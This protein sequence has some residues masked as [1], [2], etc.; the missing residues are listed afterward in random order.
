MLAFHFADDQNVL[1]IK[2]QYMFGDSI[3][4]CP[5]TEPMYFEKDSLRIEAKH[6]RAVYFPKGCEWYDYYSGTKY[7]GGTTAEVAA[8]IDIIPL[9]VK[10]GSI[11]PTCAT[12]EYAAENTGLFL[13]VYGDSPADFVLYDDEGDGFDYE[14]ADHSVTIKYDGENVISSSKHIEGIKVFR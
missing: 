5:V 11:I 13:S 12:K 3:M 6:T 9:F 10:S 8:D 4:V 2:D 7:A 14:N 1:N